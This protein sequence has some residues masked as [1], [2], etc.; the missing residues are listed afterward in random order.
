MPEPTFPSPLCLSRPQLH[1][2][3]VCQYDGKRWKSGC[4]FWKELNW[5]GI[6]RTWN[7]SGDMGVRGT[8][9]GRSA[10]NSVR[11]TPRHYSFLHSSM[12][13]SGEFPMTKC[14]RKL[15]FFGKINLEELPLFTICIRRSPN[16][17]FPSSL[18]WK[19]GKMEF[20]RKRLNGKWKRMAAGTRGG[21]SGWLAGWLDSGLGPTS[22][23]HRL[24]QK[25]WGRI[26]L[27]IN[28]KNDRMGD[29]F[30]NNWF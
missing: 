29:F 8:G 3:V 2:F 14:P 4:W 30:L 21:S 5:Q 27:G 20:I 15:E 10:F 17:P 19:G 16:F 1:P 26:D 12:S 22:Q 28:R 11:Q 9:D 25:W 24:A 13:H 23:G 18:C 6:E 7:W